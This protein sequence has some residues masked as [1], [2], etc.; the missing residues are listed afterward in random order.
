METACRQRSG[1]LG[2]SL[3]R[4]GWFLRAAAGFT[5]TRHCV[6]PQG[7]CI[8]L[9]RGDQARSRLGLQ[10]SASPPAEL[11]RSPRGDLGQSCP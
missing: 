11:C 4:L 8:C 2:P 7:V 5:L 3:A 10:R 6:R 1:A 9:G